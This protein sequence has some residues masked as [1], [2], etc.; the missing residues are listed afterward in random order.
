MIPRTASTGSLGDF[1]TDSEVPVAGPSGLGTG[2]AV[3]DTKFDV[4]AGPD[5]NCGSDGAAAPGLEAAGVAAAA[6]VAAASGTG[7]APR[8]S[9]ST[10]VETD[11][12]TLTVPAV[13]ATAPRPPN[14]S[15]KLPSEPSA[16]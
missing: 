14:R 1:P 7:P 6:E 13:K 12:A 5:A 15:I 3:A 11:D 4:G 10:V 16:S 2:V 9:G 8:F